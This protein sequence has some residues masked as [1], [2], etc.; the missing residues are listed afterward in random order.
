MWT[1]WRLTPSYVGDPG[2]GDKIKEAYTTLEFLEVHVWAI[3]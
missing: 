3:G 2:S 1:V